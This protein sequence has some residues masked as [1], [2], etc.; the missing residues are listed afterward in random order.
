MSCCLHSLR[1]PT[2]A[3]LLSSAA[4]LLAACGGGGDE[5]SAEREAPAAVASSAD[6][7][8]TSAATG[9]VLT[10]DNRWNLSKT[11]ALS[12]NTVSWTV[13][14]SKAPTIAGRLGIQG[15]M[16]VANS[17]SGAA[18]IGN[19]VVNLQKRQGNR[20]VTA[21]S[22]VADATH[23]DDA[24]RAHIQAAASSE[25]LAS[26]SENSASRAL[27][28]MD[29]TN[30]SIFSLVPQATI[31]AGSSRTLLFAAVFDNDDAALQLAPGT[32]I[33]AEVIVSFGNATPKGNSV[34]DVD[35]NGN[36]AI[37]ADEA[38]V[39][40]VASRLTLTVPAAINTSG[41]VALADTLDDITATGDVQ[42][43]NVVFNLGATGGTVTAHV[44]GGTNGGSITNCA[45]L[46]SAD[47]NVAV[48]GYS[49]PMVEGV[50]LQACSTVE[51]AASPP[52][53]T[54]GAPGCGWSADDMRTAT[55]A[56][57][58][59]TSSSAYGVL[60][61]NFSSLYGANALVV[62]GT[63]SLRFTSASAVDVFLPASGSPSVL[64]ATLTNPMSSSAGEYG[65]QV[66]ALQLN[67]DLSSLL[68]NSVA[69]GDLRIC[70][71]SAV[72]SVNGQTVDEFL[73][74]ANWILGGGS[75]TFGAATANVVANLI[76]N[77]FVDG[78][79]ST[80]AQENLVAGPCPAN[81]SIGQMRTATQTQFGDGSTPAANVLSAS[82]SSV[83]GGSLE[84][85]G[86]FIAAF[87]SA[88]AVFNYLPALGTASVL[89]AN[90]QNPIT[91]SS[92]ELGGEVLAL[93]MN[94]HLSAADAFSSAVPLGSL[95]F[96]NFV[97]L[98]SLNG[99]TVEQ[100]L[101]T[102]NHLLGGGSAPIGPSTAA[103]VARRVNGAFVDGTPSAFAQATLFAAS[104]CN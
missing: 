69:L 78:A 1:R 74:T 67:T 64:T 70:G 17:G 42:F 26:F 81:W 24:T 22:T 39:R 99:Q 9:V 37:D 25:N 15:Q 40:S 19:I 3:A 76:N 63:N 71:F 65:G 35:I 5:S 16:T 14:V 56:A 7:A 34:A 59:D 10:S 13:E 91:T 29:S 43:S 49:F 80:F 48:G 21:S 33:R 57:W 102:A 38:R 47:Q 100:F 62:G 77:A 54:P 85:G 11:G 73:T 86:T 51:V 20:W 58:G 60:A 90:V 82:F 45:R 55:Q 18:T 27:V 23:G 6:L 36:G 75:A 94:V 101:A 66:L 41:S 2:L 53:C 68:G 32:A 103:A 31:A 93:Q 83:F 95:R 104:S 87:T 88:S 52:N 72:P 92:G 50:D 8:L 61:A 30:N 84:I 46:R 97:D 89:N 96:C 28:L 79:P 98:P 12:G 4:L 44:T